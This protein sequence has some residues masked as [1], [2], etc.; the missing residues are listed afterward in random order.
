MPLE[1]LKFSYLIKA[2][3]IYSDVLSVCYDVYEVWATP[4]TQTYW[5]LFAKILSITLLACGMSPTLWYF[6]HSLALPFSEIG[7]KTDLFQ[8]CGY[9]WV[10]QIC[11]HIE[12]S[13]FTAS[14]FRIWNSSTGIPSPQLEFHHLCS[15]WCFLRPT[16]LAFQNIRL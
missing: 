7:M 6:E 10:F 9:C 1:I 13:T 14:S 3:W 2:V 4:C 15:W 8:F 11:W 5:F 12:C 16:W